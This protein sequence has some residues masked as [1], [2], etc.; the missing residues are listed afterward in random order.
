MKREFPQ[1]FWGLVVLALALAGAAVFTVAAVRDARRANDEI[2]V[3]GSAKRSIT[4]DNAMVRLTV[5]NTGFT[6]REAYPTVQGDARRVLSF[7]SAQGVPDAEVTRVPLRTESGTYTET[8][9]DGRKVERATVTLTRSFEVQSANVARVVAVSQGVGSL[10]EEGVAVQVDPV[11]YLYTR[12]ADVR[13]RLLADATRDARERAQAIAEASGAH[14]G[15]VR[16]ARMGV[17]Q[18]TPKNTTQA[19]DYGSFDTTSREKDVT[20]VVGVTFA[21]Q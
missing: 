16:S 13:I 15:A 21:V 20:A 12:L 3:T 7:L 8:L 1:L 9:P 14:V 6:A 19:D 10:I 18:I 5:S 11:Q 4:S 2:T 17:F